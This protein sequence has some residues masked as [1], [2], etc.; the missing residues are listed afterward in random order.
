MKTFPQPYQSP[1]YGMK[2]YNSEY[3]DLFDLT[4]SNG[5]GRGVARSP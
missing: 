1:S 3:K 5:Y 2:D 4:N